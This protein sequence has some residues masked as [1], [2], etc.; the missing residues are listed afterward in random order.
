MERFTGQDVRDAYVRI[1]DFIRRTPLEDAIYLSTDERRYRF[2]LESQQLGKSFK[3]RGALNAL[4]QLSRTQVERGVGAVSTGNHGIAVAYAC[5]LLGIENCVVIV[6]QGTPRSKLDRIRFY[7]ARVMTMGNTYGEAL[8]FGLNY[9]DRQELFYVDTGDAD[10]RVC[11]G[12]GTIGYELMVRHPKVDTIVVPMGTGS[13]ITGVAV[14][15]KHIKPGVRIVG[16]QTETCPAVARSLADGIPYTNYPHVGTTI[17]DSI[18]GGIGR[19]AFEMLPDLIDEII[20][21]RDAA[22]RDAVRFMVE[23]EQFTIEAASAMPVAA[24]REFP[25]RVG[26]EDV[27]LLITG[28]NVDGNVLKGIL[29]R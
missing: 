19:I 20:L 14:A 10:A 9:I 18:G 2:K 17:C 7:G 6:P 4:A 21:V 24:V 27:A 22:I 28:G 26:G 16:A 11:A 25:E 13:L 12:Y 29:A 23:M 5:T 8:T 1:C 3:V 15:A